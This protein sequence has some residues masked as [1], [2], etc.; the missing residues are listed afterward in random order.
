MAGRLTAKQTRL[1][2]EME[3]ICELVH[4]DFWNAAKYDADGRTAGLEMTKRRIVLGEVVHAYT[5]V[6]ELLSVAMC[7]FFFGRTTSFIK[8]W[9]T[10]KFRIFN[11]HI[12]EELSLLP[13]LRLVRAARPVPSGTAR[14]IERLNALRNGLAHAL[15]PENL[16]K[17]KPE[18]KGKDI[19]SLEGL[20]AF[21]EDVQRIYDYFRKREMVGSAAG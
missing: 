7:H 1:V 20:S 15:F 18:W 17:T 21:V 19:W 2:R 8:L 6:D 9:R 5:M 3:K 11:R 13:K 4:L 12:I 14:D 16:G 10:K